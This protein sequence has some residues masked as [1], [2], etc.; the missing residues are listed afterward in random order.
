MAED[1]EST[2]EAERLNDQ[3]LVPLAVAASVAY[4]H[5]SVVAVHSGGEIGEIANLVAIA[6]STVA[7]IHRAG[8][9]ASGPLLSGEI[10]GTLLKPR[11]G[12]WPSLD[13]LAIRRRDLWTAI[14]T[15][16]KARL[17]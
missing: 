12:A 8:E 6:L 14:A 13:G 11:N 10:E 4:E 2:A 15:L 7:P 5:L 1:R 3:E 17:S 16:K 9:A